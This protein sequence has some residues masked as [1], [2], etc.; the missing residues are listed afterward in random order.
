MDLG[1]LA[2]AVFSAFLAVLNNAAAD[3]SSRRARSQQTVMWSRWTKTSGKCFAV[4]SMLLLLV[5]ILQLAWR[6]GGSR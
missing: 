1:I 6:I 3:R 5:A 4:V 2:L